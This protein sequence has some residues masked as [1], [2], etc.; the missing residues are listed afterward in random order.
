MAFA[1]SSEEWGDRLDPEALAL[2]QTVGLLASLPEVEPP[3]D[4]RQRVEGGLAQTRGLQPMTCA[5]VGEAVD[6]YLGGGLNRA[7]ERA[8]HLH[9]AGCGACRREVERA[10]AAVRLVHGLDEIAPPV[11][12]RERVAAE[13][14]TRA[15]ARR[16][17]PAVRRI[18]ASV[19]P[20]AAAAA[21]ILA[22][23]TQ[24]PTSRVSVAVVPTPAVTAQ[25]P[26]PASA[27]PK[28]VVPVPAPAMV[29]A[30]KPVAAIG[31]VPGK[32][33]RAIAKIAE[34]LTSAPAVASEGKTATTGWFA[35]APEVAPAKPA[36][37]ARPVE[38]TVGI[39]EREAAPR[40]DE[41]LRRMLATLPVEEVTPSPPEPKKDESGPSRLR[42]AVAAT[43]PEAP[44][45]TSRRTLDVPR[46]PASWPEIVRVERNLPR[47]VDVPLIRKAL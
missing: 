18:F 4:L 25:H 1:E 3:A 8:L 44:P 20:L 21:L 23:R 5:Q 6:H 17:R 42:L 38:R 43:T 32:V 12:V 7:D 37:A 16:L 27:S 2:R 35:P 36:L 10:W 30:E 31:R 40:P 11:R 24:Q 26:A 41:R 45:A 39:A 29:V 47:S 13:M 19:V 14:V 46:K 9:L 22:I 28:A 15:R 34:S 33:A